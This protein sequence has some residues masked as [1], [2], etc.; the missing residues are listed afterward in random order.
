MRRPRDRAPA[1]LVRKKGTMMMV[2]GKTTSMVDLQNF[3][4]DRKLLNILLFSCCAPARLPTAMPQLPTDNTFELFVS[5]NQL[6]LQVL[7]GTAPPQSLSPSS[8]F[9]FKRS[10]CSSFICFFQ[11]LKISFLVFFVKRGHF[12][13]NFNTTIL[14]D[15]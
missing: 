9:T 5:V 4:T 1:S 10:F 15:F 6:E 12:I 14:D 3:R 7:P 13:Y 11:F 8:A 2:R